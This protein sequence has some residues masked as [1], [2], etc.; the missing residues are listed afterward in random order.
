MT[1]VSADTPP[2]YFIHGLEDT[3]KAPVQY[4]EAFVNALQEAGA[5]D[6]TY[7]RYGSTGFYVGLLIAIILPRLA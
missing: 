3:Q 5:K 4:L 6:A 7:K 1:Y 2:L